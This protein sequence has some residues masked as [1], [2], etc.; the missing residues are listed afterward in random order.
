MIEEDIL[1]F[2]VPVD[3]LSLVQVVN[4]FKNLS[5]YLPLQ[6]FISFSRVA[7]QKFLESFSVTKLHLNVENLD[8]MVSWT[9]DVFA[10]SLD[11][12]FPPYSQVS[13]VVFTLEVL[14]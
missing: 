14:G 12:V 3:D 10:L 11:S 1:W 4:S 2:N 13:F 9:I 6:L 8:A 5:V 7:P